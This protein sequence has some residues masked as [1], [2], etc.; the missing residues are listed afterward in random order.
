M[1]LIRNIPIK[2][3][4]SLWL[5]ILVFCGG[6][7]WFTGLGEALYNLALISMIWLSILAHEVAHSIAAMSYGYRTKQIVLFI[8][9]GGA[10]IENLQRLTPGGTCFVSI[11]GPLMSLFVACGLFNLAGLSYFSELG[12]TEFFKTIVMINLVLF[13][14]NLL[15]AFPMDGGRIFHA[16]SYTLGGKQL[17]D[18]L[19]KVFAGILVVVGTCYSLYTANFLLALVCGFIAISVNPAIAVLDYG[20]SRL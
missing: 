3:H 4:F 12:L 17:A 16:L 1:D 6:S 8:L 19:T 9:G 11:V 20:K 14:F 18:K 5:F 2:I 10:E 13:F 15:P 7:W